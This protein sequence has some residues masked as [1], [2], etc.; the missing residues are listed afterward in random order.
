MNNKKGK[1]LESQEVQEETY[2]ASLSQHQQSEA[3][4]SRTDEAG[5]SGYEALIHDGQFEEVLGDSTCLEIVI[6]GF[7]D[8]SEETH[9]TRPAEVIV[10]N[11]KHESLRLEDFVL[12]VASIDHVKYLRHSWW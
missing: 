10:E 1:G 12:G 11:V 9:G 2:P 3:V 7:A 6:I 5:R 8:A 4:G